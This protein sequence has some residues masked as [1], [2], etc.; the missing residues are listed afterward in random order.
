MPAQPIKARLLR[1]LAILGAIV[2]PLIAG[3]ASFGLL[4]VLRLQAARR[5][6]DKLRT[7]DARVSEHFG[8][9]EKAAAAVHLLWSEGLLDPARPD[10]ARVVL[11]AELG[12]VPGPSRIMLVRSN[13]GLSFF[14]RYRNGRYQSD[15]IRPVDAFQSAFQRSSED[16][17]GRPVGSLEA[18]TLPYQPLHRSWVAAAAGSPGPTW[19]EPYQFASFPEESG[20]RYLGMTYAAAV[21]GPSGAPRGFVGIDV[22]L[23]DLSEMAASVRPTPSSEVVVLDDRNRVVASSTGS[24]A[25]FYLKGPDGIDSPVARALLDQDAAYAGGADREIDFRGTTW[26]GRIQPLATSSPKG[27]RVAVAI[28]EAELI[29]EARW[30]LV[31]LFAALAALILAVTLRLGLL[32]RRL[33]ATLQKLAAAAREVG[34]AEELPLPTAEL[35]LGELRS[36]SV[37]LE[38]SH[39]AVREQRRLQEQLTHSQRVALVGFL[40]GGLAHDINNQLT[41][42][43]AGIAEGRAALDPADR[44]TGP[45]EQA[46]RACWRSVEAIRG[47]LGLGRRGAPAFRAVEINEVVR[48]TASLVERVLDRRV[49]LELQLAPELPVIS[50]D[51][52]QIEQ[53]L[54]NLALNARDAMPDGGVLRMETRAGN[55]GGIEIAVS[56]TGSGISPEIRPRIFEPFFTTKQAG[57]GTGLGLAMVASI[58]RGHGGSVEVDSELGRG[59]VFRMNLAQEPAP[60]PLPE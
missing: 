17:G 43:L 5:T 18:S 35:T 14:A 12:Q 2:I 51:P 40:A 36:L 19:T 29:G 26:F 11:F 59:T 24:S 30:Q 8:R 45:L 52:I 47:L 15:I 3:L 9:I 4:H 44:A 20:D 13:D 37:A 27:W 48:E 33:S 1:E 58:V 32:A 54:L 23:D 16:R 31:A 60:N 57:Q 49:R 21:R 25:P 41:T 46:E 53:V 22:L 10:E 34:K 55:E 39:K 42:V 7:L 38:R 28:P 6:S 56:D 50:A